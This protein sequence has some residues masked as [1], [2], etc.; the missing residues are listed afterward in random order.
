MRH[1]HHIYEVVQTEEMRRDEMPQ[2]HPDEHGGWDEFQ[3]EAVTHDHE[4]QSDHEDGVMHTHLPPPLQVGTY[5]ED[6]RS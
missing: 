1:T 5:L 2:D 6:D 4:L 3:L